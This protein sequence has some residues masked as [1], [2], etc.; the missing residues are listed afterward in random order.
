MERHWQPVLRIYMT[1]FITARMSVC[2]LPPPLFA[3]GMSDST[4]AHSSSVRSLGYLRLSRLYFARFLS[5]HIGGRP[6]N[7]VINTRDSYDSTRFK[8]DTKEARAPS[9]SPG[10]AACGA[11]G[12]SPHSGR[13]AE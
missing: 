1:P 4:S 6:S 3:G 7:Q 2:R 8:T 13:G 9:P 11:W 12:S 10:S 5:V